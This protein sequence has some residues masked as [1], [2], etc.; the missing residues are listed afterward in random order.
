M[1]GTDKIYM[2]SAIVCFLIGAIGYIGTAYG[3]DPI[4]LAIG[5]FIDAALFDDAAQLEAFKTKYGGNYETV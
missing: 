3:F 4:A 2:W 5:E 1:T